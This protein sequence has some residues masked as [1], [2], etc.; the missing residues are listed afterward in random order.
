VSKGISF[1]ILGA[2]FFL[3]MFVLLTKQY[4][5]IG[6]N[7]IKSSKNWILIYPIIII[8][9]GILFS[10]SNGLFSNASIIGW[11]LI[12]T[13]FVGISEELMFRGILLSA[14][15][16]KIGFI[17]TVIVVTLLFGCVHILNGFVTGNFLNGIMQ[18]AF[19]SFS[20]ILFIGIRVKTD[21]I[22]PAILLHWMWDFTVFIV[23]SI[24][25]I[26]PETK[27][28]SVEM[29]LLIIMSI[30]GISPVI[31]GILGIIQI[32]KKDVVKE[33]EATQIELQ[34]NYTK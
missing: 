16:N 25:Y 7:R 1:P 5:L 14:L 9:I 2:A 15:T 17:K 33:F 24:K 10:I 6:F 3:V 20:G 18:A 34:K 11:I 28:D 23:S 31:F 29:P 13:L 19:A 22:I 26:Q 27:S 8:L 4:S 30:L 32:S 21:S 12:N